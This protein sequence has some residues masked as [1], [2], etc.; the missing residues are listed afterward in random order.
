MSL[1]ALYLKMFILGFVLAGLGIYAAFVGGIWFLAK[2]F[3][4]GIWW[5]LASLVIPLAGLV[6]AVKHWSISWR[7]LALNIVGGL[8]AAGGAALLMMTV[9][10]EA[11][12]TIAH[13]LQRSEQSAMIATPPLPAESTPDSA[14][15]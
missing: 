9:M 2:A 13:G 8:G 15:P 3:G 12:G 14:Q 11:Q 1:I 7:P 5:G 4:V 6:F 10:S